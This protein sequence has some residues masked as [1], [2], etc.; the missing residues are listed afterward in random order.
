M[1]D[2]DLGNSEAFFAFRDESLVDISQLSFLREYR[3]IQ[4]CIRI[5]E[6][7]GYP[8][9]HHGLFI[10]LCILSYESSLIQPPVVVAGF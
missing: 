1:T 8:P 9:D 4:R 2:A 7:S 6:I 5:L 3:G 10:H